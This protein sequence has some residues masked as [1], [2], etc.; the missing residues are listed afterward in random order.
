MGRKGHSIFVLKWNGI[1]N[2]FRF[3]FSLSN[4]KTKFQSQFRFSIKIEKWISV[5]FFYE[6]F[7]CWSTPLTSYVTLI[8]LI[9]RTFS[10]IFNF[11]KNRKQISNFHF[12]LNQILKFKCSFWMSFFFLIVMLNFRICDKVFSGPGYFFSTYCFRSLSKGFWIERDI[13]SCFYFFN[14]FIQEQWIRCQ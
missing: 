12:C 7:P 2:F 4:W 8:T 5:L 6:I 3:S 13:L 11:L 1:L 10:F 9:K 14:T